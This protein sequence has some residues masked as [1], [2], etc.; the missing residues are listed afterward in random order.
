MRAG[1]I[2]CLRARA[3]HQVVGSLAACCTESEKPLVTW[4]PLHFGF[5]RSIRR[6]CFLV[7]PVAASASP[8]LQIM[9][10]AA[11]R[12]L[13]KK[14]SQIFRMRGLALRPEAARHADRAHVALG[15]LGPPH[16]ARRERRG[17][18]DE[19]RRSVRLSS[20]QCAVWS[21][22]MQDRVTAR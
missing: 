6:A 8:L 3:A 7:G 12:A 14:L 9:P 15:A 4:H 16:I 20:E 18:P 10:N 11:E 2:D 1:A 13:N 19:T 21:E 22:G 17:A 5:A